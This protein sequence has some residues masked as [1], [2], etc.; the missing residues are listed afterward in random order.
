MSVNFNFSLNNKLNID[1]SQ[2]IYG[3]VQQN[4]RS[5]F[6]TTKISVKKR[7]WNAKTKRVKSSDP[8]YVYKNNV[9]DAYEMK[10]KKINLEYL[11]NDM[12]LSIN[13]FITGLKNDHHSKLSFSQFAKDVIKQKK[14]NVKKLTHKNYKYQLN[15]VLEFKTDL[16]I[17]DIDYSFLVNYQNFLKMIKKNNEATQSKSLTFVRMICNEAVKNDIITKS[18]FLKFKIKEIAGREEFLS[19][20]ELNK[21]EYLYNEARIRPPAQHSLRYFLFACYTGISF[22]DLSRLTFGDIK[23]VKAKKGSFK[24]LTSERLKTGTKYRVPLTEKALKFLSKKFNPKQKLFKM[25]ENQTTNR[26]LKLIQDEARIK[27]NITFHL[28]R[29]TFGTHA[30]SSGINQNLVMEMMGHKDPRVNKI[31]SKIQDFT[32][33]DAFFK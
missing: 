6:L 14:E 33:V 25:F 22:S 27:Q 9:L 28:S 21:L 32:L 2:S 13:K 7:Y 3:R 11:V 12:P 15:K 24:L 29:H 20:E 19:T 23:E 10:A 1:G 26:H 18:P 5:K 16:N 4:Q 31:Y 30:I 17:M 8:E